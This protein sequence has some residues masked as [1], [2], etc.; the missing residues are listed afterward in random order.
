VPNMAGGMLEVY[1]PPS[2]MFL[3]SCRFLGFQSQP[4]YDWILETD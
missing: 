3:E 4:E 2:E 1:A